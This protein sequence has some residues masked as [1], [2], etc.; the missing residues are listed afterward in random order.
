MLRGPPRFWRFISMGVR[1]VSPTQKLDAA[2]GRSSKPVRI[3]D[4]G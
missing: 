3:F 1:G 4:G 2:G